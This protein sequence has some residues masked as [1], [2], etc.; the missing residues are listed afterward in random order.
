LVILKANITEVLKIV[1][2][3]EKWKKD[4]KVIEEAIK[5]KFGDYFGK[6]IINALKECL[7]EHKFNDRTRIANCVISKLVEGNDEASEPLNQEVW[8]FLYHFVIVG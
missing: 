1:L 5:L 8:D 4:G 7:V 2:S 6:R 3:E